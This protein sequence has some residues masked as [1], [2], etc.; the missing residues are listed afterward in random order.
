MTESERIGEALATLIVYRRWMPI[1]IENMA[2]AGVRVY[3]HGAENRPCVDVTEF[4]LLEALE[5]A[6]KEVRG[7]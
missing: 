1:E 3:C 2:T 7:W 4:S 5:K 6:A